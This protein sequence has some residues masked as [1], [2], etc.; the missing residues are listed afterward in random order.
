M[1]HRYVI[2]GQ[3]RKCSIAG[4]GNELKY[5]AL[6]YCSIKCSHVA[7][8]RPMT[9]FHRSRRNGVEPPRGQRCMSDC[10]RWH[11]YRCRAESFLESGGV[12]GYVAPQFLSRVLKD[13][14]G[15]RCLKCG[16]SRRHPKTGKVPIEV[17]HIDGNWQNS[18]LTNLTLLCPNCHALTPTFRALNR[19]HGRA[20]RLSASTSTEIFPDLMGSAPACLTLE[21]FERTPRQLEFLLPT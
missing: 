10:I 21:V 9:V 15:E 8:K 20:H 4:C 3:L 11:T 1:H 13:Y 7:Q 5:G 14:Y 17:E 12:F 2:I 6:K 19:G 16:W 18:R